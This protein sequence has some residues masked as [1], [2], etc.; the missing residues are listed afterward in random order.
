MVIA[1]VIS[2]AGVLLAF[3]FRVWA[4]WWSWTGGWARTG[5]LVWLICIGAGGG[6]LGWFAGQGGGSP[7]GRLL[8]DGVLFGI[9]G[10]AILRVDV[11]PSQVG[12]S[13]KGVEVQ[14]L[15]GGR[16]LLRAALQW[17]RNALD[18]EL[19]RQ[20]SRYLHE[21]PTAQ[22]TQLANGV[23]GDIYTTRMTVDD[24]YIHQAKKSLRA[25]RGA[26]KDSKK[27]A[28]AIINLCLVYLI[29]I[30]ARREDISVRIGAAATK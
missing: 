24:R 5:A 19:K 16:S 26:S 28:A 9:I 8:I 10:A 29:Y 25:M 27:D 11:G 6:L 12:R 13:T 17:L 22:L 4:C 30:H 23:L 3:E 1:C 2:L 20:A 15:G 7:T 18:D 14:A 21:L